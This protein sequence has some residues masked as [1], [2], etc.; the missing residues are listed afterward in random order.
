[1]TLA[2]VYAPNNDDPDFFHV[3]FDHLS[4]FRCDE[5]IICGDFNLVLDIEKDKKNGIAG[6][7]Q[8]GFCPGL[9]VNEG[10]IIVLPLFTSLCL[11]VLALSDN[12]VHN[13]S[14]C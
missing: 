14:V 6:T 7:H 8:N 1:M 3:F 10:I 4:N 5:I 9:P 13:F 11:Y 12:L 2:N